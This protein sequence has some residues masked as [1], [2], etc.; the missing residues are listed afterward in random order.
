MS[1]KYRSMQLI[2]NKPSRLLKLYFHGCV[3]LLGMYETIKN[4]FLN[5]AVTMSPFCGT[6]GTL[7]F[8]LQLTL[9]MGFKARVDAP[10]ALSVICAQWIV[11][12]HSDD[13]GQDLVPILHLGMVRLPHSSRPGTSDPNHLR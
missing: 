3:F 10:P 7:C 1:H 6:T 9:P 11:R 8:G 13:P 5:V 2:N 4:L 12:V